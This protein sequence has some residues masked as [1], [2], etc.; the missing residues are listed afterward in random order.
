MNLRKE[1]FMKK[2]WYQSIELSSAELFSM[3]D[4]YVSVN[5]NPRSPELKLCCVYFKLFG[6][7][8]LNSSKNRRPVLFRQFVSSVSELTEPAGGVTF[9]SLSYDDCNAIPLLLMWVISSSVPSFVS[10][11]WSE[12]DGVIQWPEIKAT[13]LAMVIPIP[14]K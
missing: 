11:H 3:E 9:W 6:H 8:G 13:F 7:A 1:N 4:D 14:V 2:K 5:P 10:N 12:S